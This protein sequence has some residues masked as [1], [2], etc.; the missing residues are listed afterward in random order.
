MGADNSPPVGL[1]SP[2]AMGSQLYPTVTG[3]IKD[4]LQP[5]ALQGTELEKQGCKSQ[6]N[7][8]SVATPPLDQPSPELYG[9]GI[10]D[11]YHSNRSTITN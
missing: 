3:I 10:R 7:A 8:S 5:I 2:L 9:Y 1:V 11:L 4:P 6:H